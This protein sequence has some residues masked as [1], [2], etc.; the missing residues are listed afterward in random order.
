MLKKSLYVLPLFCM[1]SADAV[2][3]SEQSDMTLSQMRQALGKQNPQ[4]YGLEDNEFDA[5]CIASFGE[6]RQ[7]R[8]LKRNKVAQMSEEDQIAAF[9]AME[10]DSDGELV[11]AVSNSNVREEHDI[12]Y[13]MARTVD[14]YVED[15]KSKIAVLNG[16]KEEI[17]NGLTRF[18]L[19]ADEISN[20]IEN[21]QGFNACGYS[22]SN[23]Y[24]QAESEVKRL[25]IESFLL[26][27][28]KTN[29]AKV[30][31]EIQHLFAE[32]DKVKK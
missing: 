9:M 19:D 5:I 17:A 10:D 3:A 30:E 22:K 16:Q 8:E 29:L 18:D 6:P 23:K 21:L 27:S 24:Q 11:A 25:K 1:L 15:L 28:E 14:T 26:L 2:F 12:E 4:L 7:S 13:F 32:I 20:K 31:A